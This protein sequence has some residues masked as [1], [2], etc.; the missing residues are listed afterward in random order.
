MIKREVLNVIPETIYM[1]AIILHTLLH[2]NLQ[3]ILKTVKNS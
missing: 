1:L 2:I 3:H